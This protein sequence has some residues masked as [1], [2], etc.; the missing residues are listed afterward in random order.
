M[1]TEKKDYADPKETIEDE[2]DLEVCKTKKFVYSAEEKK[3]LKKVNLATGPFIIVICLFQFIDKST[4]NFSTA[5]GLF[6]ETGIDGGQFSW[7]GAIFY[8]G[9][10][11]YQLP[12]QFLL[13]KLPIA[14]YL[15]VMLVIWGAVLAC[16]SLAH[17]FSQLAA[18]RFLLG[19]FE[20]AA[21]PSIYLIVSQVYRRTEQVIWFGVIMGCNCLA[22]AVGG[23]I[24]YGFWNMHGLHGL[25]A[26]RWCMIILGCV[27]AAIGFV[28]FFFLPDKAKSRWYR[29]SPKEIEIVEERMI[30]NTVTQTKIIK[31]AHIKEA[32][33]EVQFYCYILIS[34]L[35]Q[36]TNGCTSIFS[37]Q[38][39]KGMGFSN[40]ES[41]L[42]N[43]PSGFC[44]L[45]LTTAAVILSHRYNENGYVGAFFSCI[46]FI[47]VLL[48]V[49]LPRGGSMLAGLFLAPIGPAYMILTAM[50]SNNI[51]GY[52][53]RVFYNG[54]Q[55]VAFS[56]GNF[57]GPLMM[58]PEQ[59]PQYLG[60]MIGYMVTNLA[61]AVLF[62]LVRWT[63]AK[64]NRRRQQMKDEGKL[65]PNRENDQN[66]DMTD[67]ED[68]YFIYRP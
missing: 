32:L 25:S 27:T 7:L 60:G 47:G 56:L 8:M 39:I 68:L 45:F 43:I 67:I 41:I 58:R 22:A 48:L 1:A 65:P 44:S 38:I 17:N 34:F 14:K 40:L 3:V 13:Q 37:T 66:T 20:A 49:V 30:D 15:G 62:L 50:I 2:S 52:T 6:E 11:A 36:L 35:L 9:Y 64:E 23:L 46:S 10:L 18:I 31:P 29:L 24:G 28:T 63:L 21:Y 4:L 33:K 5:M 51:T 42:L 59:A 61:S 55:I 12:N 19:F 53:K 57:V 16:T 26:W 54:A